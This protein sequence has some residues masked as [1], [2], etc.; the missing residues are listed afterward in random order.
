MFSRI[1]LITLGLLAASCI[2]VGRGAAAESLAFS[3]DAKQWKLAHQDSSNEV[4]IMEFVPPGETIEAWTELCTMM[5]MRLASFDYSTAEEAVAAFRASLEQQVKIAEWQVVAR[6]E[7]SV[8]VWWSIQGDGVHDSQQELVRYISGKSTM[9]RLSFT[10]KADS[11]SKEQV[12]RWLS[13]LK[14]AEVL[15]Q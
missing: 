10:K 9:Y 1:C 12:L 5:Q 8:T 6:D 3:V 13:E 15:F 7:S 2:S 14:K 4:R 11:L